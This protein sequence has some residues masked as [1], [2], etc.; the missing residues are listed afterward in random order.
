[1]K[2]SL[3]IVAPIAL[4]LLF[5][6]G[7]TETTTTT[8]ASTTSPVQEA[9][10]PPT[11]TTAAV[12]TSASAPV[13]TS[14]ALASQDTNWPGIAADITEFRRKG[15]TLTAKIRFTNKGS[16]ET[17]V[18]VHYDD[19][20]LVD[21]TNAKKYEVLKDEKGTYIAGVRAGY[22]NQ[23]F[24]RI[25]AGQTRTI[26]AKFPAP[27][28]EVKTITLQMEKIPPFEDLTIQD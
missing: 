18:N 27:P 23:W 10:P 26:W 5:C 15:N 16:A 24:E 25:P 3:V 4:S 11:T 21:T 9:A 2:R 19:M 8:S 20:S 1:M 17:E 6:K 22:N 28:P 14:G 12:A 7:A 13:S